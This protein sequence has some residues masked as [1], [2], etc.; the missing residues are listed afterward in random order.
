M[1][2]VRPGHYANVIGESVG[3]ATLEEIKFEFRNDDFDLQWH[4]YLAHAF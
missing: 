2:R 1:A 3:L 4:G